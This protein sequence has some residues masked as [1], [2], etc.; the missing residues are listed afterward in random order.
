VILDGSATGWAECGLDLTHATGG[1]VE[2]VIVSH[3]GS[4][5]L[6]AGEAFVVRDCV[7][8]DNSSIGIVVGEACRI[9]GNHCTSNGVGIL[10]NGSNSRIESNSVASCQRTGISVSFTAD[11]N[12][13]LGNSVIGTTLED[14]IE[15]DIFT[16]GNLILNNTVIDNA[17][18]G[19]DNGN[20]PNLN[21]AF[22]NVGFL[23]MQNFSAVSPFEMSPTNST[24]AWSNLWR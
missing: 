5:G 21:E 7:S 6:R 10:L 14:G 1:I 16:T 12:L 19:I 13:I 18:V 17:G 15:F 23:N 3:C 4:D 2:N 11:N 9:V 24:G 22:G 20:S 8:R